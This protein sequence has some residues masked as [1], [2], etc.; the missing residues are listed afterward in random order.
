MKKYL[1]LFVFD[2]LF[3][4]VAN[5][6]IQGFDYNVIIDK[7]KPNHNLGIASL[8][9]EI[10]IDY[11]FD[12]MGTY[13]DGLC[14]VKIDDKYRYIDFAG[15]YLKTS[16][17][18]MV[19]DFYNGFSLVY[20]INKNRFSEK[21]YYGF[22][23][24]NGTAVIPCTLDYNYIYGFEGE[25]AAVYKGSLSKSGQPT[26]GKYGLINKKGEE[27]TKCIY[28][29]IDLIPNKPYAM[30]FIGEI[31]NKGVQ[32]KGKVGLIN[33]KG[34]II[35]P[36]QFDE[37]YV[38]NDNS[39]TA[40]LQNTENKKKELQI[41]VYNLNGEIVIPLTTQ[42]ADIGSISENR[43]QV[44]NGSK[45]GYLDLKS[46]LIIGFDY[47][48]GTDFSFNRATVKKDDNWFIIDTLGNI[49]NSINADFSICKKFDQNKIAL[50]FKGK[51]KNNMPVKGKYGLMNMDGTVI[52]ECIYDTI[53]S[54]S[55]DVALV[56]NKKKYGFI[57]KTGKEIIPI[58]YD[59]AFSFSD[60]LACV[61][62][63]FY[64]GFIDVSNQVVIPFKYYYAHPFINGIA[65]VFSEEGKQFI[66]TNGHILY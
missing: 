11:Q 43:I 13:N 53:Y 16:E 6:Q 64:Y 57:D 60:G 51:T 40:Y 3:V 21:V 41:C 50:T 34:E 37:V 39:V 46:N 31:D 36:V 10:I 17:F 14:I 19:Y 45:F 52:V 29:D 65:K 42:Y 58:H 44:S 7:A 28:D 54:Y 2:L 55:E 66:I 30:V 47:D 23:D 22:I 49:I 9:N 35:I 24:T 20:L 62:K 5:S 15:N 8:N 38:G 4:F 1:L 56:R 27:T 59:F 25:V 63:D 26:I 12:L 61:K 48:Y 32:G 18:D 33:T